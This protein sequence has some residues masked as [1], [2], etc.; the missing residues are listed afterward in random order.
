MTPASLA[1]MA[2][3]LILSFMIVVFAIF[4]A[5]AALRLYYSNV[6]QTLSPVFSAILC[7]RT[8]LDF[9]TGNAMRKV[10]GLLGSGMLAWGI[11]A[12]LFSAYP[13][14]NNGA[15]TPYPYYSD[16]GYLAL[17]PL[18]IVA[19]F[20]LK[21]TLGVV[22][23]LWGKIVSVLLFFGALGLSL[24]ANWSGLSEGGIILLVS[25]CY[26]VFDPILLMAT[27]L[28]ASALYGGVVGKAWWYVLGGLVLYFLGNQ[29]YTYLVFTEQYATGSPID[30]LWVLG[31]GMV[32]IAAMMTHTLFKGLR[33]S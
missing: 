5:D 10:W 33:S 29:I 17:V 31:F 28:V 4:D 30:I 19:L 14:L 6:I 27:M 15:E 23:P 16:I 21:N 7:Y 9:P 11:G 18:V 24:M 12:A 2:I 8:A 20:L 25:V 13:L 26:I 32:A 3:W 1:I 22:P